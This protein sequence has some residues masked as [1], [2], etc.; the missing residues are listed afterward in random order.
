MSGIS[1]GIGLIS[2]INTS[3]LIDQLMALEARPITSLQNRSQRLDAQRTAYLA[4]SAQ[5]LAIQNAVTNFG[6]L[7]FFRKFNAVSS[8]ENVLSAV[9]GES[10]AIGTTTF[11]VHSLVSNHVVATRGFADADRTPVGVGTI[12]VE[13]G[14]GR[15][16][17]STE[18]NALNGGRG[19]RRGVITI[20]DRSGASADIDLSRAFT[21]QDVINAINSNTDINVHA[22][23][24][25]VASNGASG[26]RIVIE[27]LAGGTGNLIVAD[28][29]DGFAAADLG[30]A[31]NVAGDRI[32]GA[33]IYSI[34][35]STLLQSLN[36]GNGVDRLRQ[37]ANGD[38]I[39]FS[40][41]F[42]DFGVSLTDVLR[43][44]TDLRALNG[45]N[46]IRL[47]VIRITDRSGA[48]AE[49]DLSDAKT[50]QDVITAINGAGL[51]VS[52]TTVNSYIQIADTSNA[53]GESAKNL[54][55]EDVSGFAAADLGIAADI[56]QASIRGRD[57]YRVATVGD[58]VRAINYAPG[59][60][61]LVEASIS[62]DGNGITLRA[63]GFDNAVTVTEGGDSDG[64]VS[65][66]V[67]DLGLLNVTFSTNEPYTS[68]PLIGG[69]N[70][71]L[72]SS[73]RGGQ[74]VTAGV[75]SIT[76]ASGQAAEIDLSSART[77][78]DVIDLINADPTISVT[79]GL[80][81]AQN[82][83]SLRDSG[84]VGGTVEIHDIS[85]N[86]ASDLGFAGS[87]ELAADGAINGGN[88]QLQ[89]V[90]R[91]TRLTDLNGGRGVNL[92]TLRITDARGGV[93]QTS[94]ASNLTNVGQV[95][96]KINESTPNTIEA[97][98]NDTGDGIIIID[99]S[100]GPGRLTIEDRDGSTTATDL[101][102]AGSAAT[103]ANSI[104][105]SYETKIIVGASDTLKSI[106][107]KL[108][109]AKAGFSAS[110]VNDGGSANPFGLTVTSTVSGRRGELVIDSGEIDLGLATL[111]RAQDAVI[112]V[113]QGESGSGKLI[114]SSTNT[115]SDVIPGVT[116][117][118]LSAAPESVTVNTT[119]DVDS[120]VE[121]I[122]TFVSAYN[123][124]Q[125]SIDDATHYNSDTQ[126]RGPLLGDSTVALIRS[127]LQRA[128]SRSFEG[129]DSRASRLF[130][131]GLRIG[132]NNQLQFD[133]DRFRTTYEQS[134]EAVETLFTFAE[135][136]FGATLKQ[137]LDDLT[138]GTDGFIAHKSDLIGDQQQ[139]I[140][141]RIDSL[142][143]LLAA[144]R[145]RL[146]AQFAGLE[147]ALA[148]LQDQQNSLSELAALAAQ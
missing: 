82:G 116:V 38:D 4:I 69:L 44:S 147:T 56:D 86:L 43:T 33:D 25:G 122:Q 7:S 66:T 11:R 10:A 112:S 123:D 87:F 21:V 16:N 120:I 119:Q 61:S 78:Q 18:L 109:T 9:A 83:I 125:K 48:S 142:N 63:L 54:K 113:G 40:T 135:T 127:R 115:L 80:N 19:V 77:L 34:S 3:Q 103:G 143:I 41:S 37:G 130:S 106:A 131:I 94:L 45:G 35:A 71:V 136:G 42:G 105:G 49:I 129:V 104:D 52:A 8:N 14:H 146:E 99:R 46:G 53:T 132:A 50:A 51:A 134:P 36:D 76:D 96:D 59:N 75:I 5:I 128:V 133:E 72:L 102:L 100:E 58:L 117:N 145:K 6:K 22:S 90:S 62:E 55:V 47:G 121:A 93:Y 101:R 31:A 124:A 67:K 97:R 17:Q 15:V 12:S 114:T 91:Q 126:D 92:G 23:V 88:L 85:G 28:K 24:T 84:G 2:G 140:T 27:D 74:G 32:D 20:A 64:T 39:H 107:D 57:L 89:Y 26:D 65:Q 79:A 70:S 29:L 138:R 73:L 60:A 148:G 141:D 144:K 13:V 108:N 98:I 118:L 30:I 81:A 110:I 1:S 95:I 139:A 137:T 111:T 68:R